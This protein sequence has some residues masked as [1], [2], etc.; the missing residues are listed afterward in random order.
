MTREEQIKQ[1]CAEQGFPYGACSGISSVKAIV[2][3]EAIKWADE[4]PDGSMVKWHT[5]GPK[6]NGEYLVSLED[7]SVCRDEWRELY[8]DDDIKCWVYN[9]GEVTAWCKLSDIA[10]Y[11]EEN[12]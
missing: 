1:Y 8:C 9:E 2:A 10:P 3:T 7:G 4:H 6:E 11:K 12:I 5:G